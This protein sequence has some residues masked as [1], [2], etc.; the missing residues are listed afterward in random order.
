MEVHKV[1]V[2]EMNGI[3][4]EALNLVIGV[5]LEVDVL[6]RITRDRIVDGGRRRELGYR[7][8]DL[9]VVACKVR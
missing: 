7:G 4:F 2:V 5:G 8:Q 6:R 3:G 9:V 1:G